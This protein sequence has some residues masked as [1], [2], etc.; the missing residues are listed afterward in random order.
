MPELAM[1]Q[2]TQMAGNLSG[3]YNNSNNNMN[4]NTLQCIQV[5]TNLKD[6]SSSSNNP[7]KR[8]YRRR[9]SIDDIDINIGPRG[10]LDGIM[11]NSV[12]SDSRPSFQSMDDMDI[13]GTFRSVD[14]MDLMSIGNSINDIID[15]DIKMNPEMRKKYGRRLSNA[16][17]TKGLPDTINDFL[18][19]RMGGDQTIEIK[20]MDHGNGNGGGGAKKKKTKKS[21]DPRLLAPPQAVGTRHSVQ[22]K[23]NDGP[24]NPGMGGR[25]S[26]LSMN[27]NFDGLDDD[28][29]MSFGNM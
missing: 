11:F 3:I 12:S 19:N 13:R 2:T 6:G 20:T 16:S 4:N 25:G 23:G 15:E 14:T 17:R 24:S 10:T 28:S 26:Q 29:R 18:V 7:N 27:M 8:P 22:T 21:I 1:S 9:Q 5:S